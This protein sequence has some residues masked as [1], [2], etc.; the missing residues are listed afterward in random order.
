[1]SFR[2]SGLFCRITRAVHEKCAAGILVEAGTP[3][4]IFSSAREERTRRLLN[5]VGWE[6]RA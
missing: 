2:V 3:S 4:E 5:Q 6:R 1:M